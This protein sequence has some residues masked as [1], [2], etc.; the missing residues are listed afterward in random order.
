MGI[1][2]QPHIIELEI[3]N[4]CKNMGEVRVVTV[5]DDLKGVALIFFIVNFESVE[6]FRATVVG[7][8]SEVC[9]PD[10]IIALDEFP[11]NRNG[12]VDLKRLEEMALQYTVKI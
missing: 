4:L 10:R 9:K 11:L 8:L 2:I 7:H 12:K 1:M 3:Q 5:G 6:K